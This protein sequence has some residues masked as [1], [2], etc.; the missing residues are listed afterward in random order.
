MRIIDWIS[1]VCSS[2]LAVVAVARQAA[3][4]P[5]PQPGAGGDDR[6]VRA[7]LAAG[8]A[9]AGMDAV[10]TV[11][12]AG[13]ATD[14]GADGTAR[15]AARTALARAPAALRPGRRTRPG[16]DRAGRRLP[17]VRGVLQPG[18]DRADAVARSGGHMS[19][20]QSL[21]HTTYA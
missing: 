15:Q 8:A 11:D 1:D 10:G 18:R 9:R 14:R 6:A 19:A 20:L 13:G 5:A 4:Q 21:M 12:A 2:D 7:R 16:A 17:A 3:R